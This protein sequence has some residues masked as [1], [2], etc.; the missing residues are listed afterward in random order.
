MTKGLAGL[1]VLAI[2][3]AAL[4]ACEDDGS[5]GLPADT[6]PAIELTL[7]PD[8]VTLVPGQSRQ[9]LAVITGTAN[10]AAN[11]STSAASVATVDGGGRV[12]ALLPGTAVIQAVAQADTRARD[13]T[14]VTVKPP[15]PPL[16]PTVNIA[17]ITQEGSTTI[18]DLDD[19]QG[20][21]QVTTSLGIPTG[22]SV[23]RVEFL[24]DGSEI[25]TCSHDVS[26]GEIGTPTPVPC[27]INTAAYDTLTGQVATANGPRVLLVRAIMTNDSIGASTTRVLRLNNPGFLLARVRA[28]RE[29]VESVASPRSLAE[30]ALWNSGSITVTIQPVLFWQ[31]P[32]DSISRVAVTIATSGAGVSG[33]DDCLSTGVAAAGMG[34]THDPTIA[35][36]D[37]GGGLAGANNGASPNCAPA[38]ALQTDVNPT[39]GFSVTFPDVLPLSNGGLAGVEDSLAFFIDAITNGQ[40]KGPICINPGPDNPLTRAPDGANCGTGLGS[41]SPA[42]RVGRMGIWL[43]DNLAPRFTMLNIRR[44]GLDPFFNS[45]TFASVAGAA[46]ADTILGAYTVDYGVGHQ[47]DSDN[48][49]FLAGLVLTEMVA[50]SNTNELP[51]SDDP[52]LLQVTIKDAL[53]NTRTGTATANRF[54][55]ASPYGFVPEGTGASV[56]AFGIDF[57]RPTIA[58]ASS[59]PA[60]NSSSGTSAAPGTYVLTPEDD[61]T[62]ASGFTAAP[63]QIKAELINRFGTVCYD[64]EMGATMSCSTG[65]GTLPSDGQFDLTSGV[66]GYWRVTWT[67]ADRAGNATA[68]QTRTH[69]IDAT[70]PTIGSISVPATITG[71]QSVAISATLTDNV[72]LKDYRSFTSYAENSLSY[73]ILASESNLGGYGPDPLGSQHAASTTIPTFIRSIE[74][75][76]AG[77]PTSVIA[78]ATHLNYQVRDQLDNVTGQAQG[79]LPLI[80]AAI[81]GSGQETSWRGAGRPFS[82]SVNPVASYQNTTSATS[83]CVDSDGDGCTT[84]STITLTATATGP[85]LTFT[86][87]FARVNFYYREA[88][89]GLL[90]LI[91]TGSA[92]SNDNPATNTRTWTYSASFTTPSGLA[93]GGALL[94]MAIGVDVSGRGLAATFVN[95]MQVDD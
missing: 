81:G 31:T 53:G 51:E 45:Q 77:L 18:V 43:H 74:S 61:G 78:R 55:I 56:Q 76:A 3:A 58:V 33:A 70:F 29:P 46:P 95:I 48:S 79:I 40:L 83:I 13:A 65:G 85:A 9:L 39:N 60:N 66:D 11:W 35:S 19:V 38:Q 12:T 42:K 2:A 37:G 24:L 92:A 91:A 20:T 6:L 62:G 82:P 49:T 4:A 71:G 80:S 94:V 5:S 25:E 57:T 32:S 89:T 84:P 72:E 54:V 28:S 87:P 86:N 15:P 23:D 50:F 22:A 93:V 8:T 68:P 17:S 47:T 67:L 59:T 34:G 63:F 26:A 36:M 75:S 69:L 21:I 27:V 41:A 7:V 30:E 52:Y 16:L 10:Q 44:G 73:T 88:A 64:L 90:V 1:L 14:V